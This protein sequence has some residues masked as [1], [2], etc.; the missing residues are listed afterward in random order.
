M[1]TEISYRKSGFGLLAALTRGSVDEGIRTVV[2]DLFIVLA[3]NGVRAFHPSGESGRR[4][5]Q[6]LGKIHWHSRVL[7][8]H[9]DQWGVVPDR[10][11][12]FRCMALATAPS[13][14]TGSFNNFWGGMRENQLSFG[15]RVSPAGWWEVQLSR[16]FA[17]EQVREGFVSEYAEFL[18]R[19]AG[20]IQRGLEA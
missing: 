14:I 6:A 12:A 8:E 11:A 2:R 1:V 15:F 19:Y 18:E 16:N 5:H 3:A 10:K 20:V 17:A 7:W 9:A 4:L 13:L